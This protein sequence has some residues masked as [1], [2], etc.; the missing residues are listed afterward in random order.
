MGYLAC[1]QCGGYYR[2]LDDESP[3][4]FDENCECGGKLE[5]FESLGGAR[6]N[7]TYGNIP[8]T[9]KNLSE[10]YFIPLM[11]ILVSLECILTIFYTL[12]LIIVLGV[13]GL[14]FG[15][16]MLVIRVKGLENRLYPKSRQKIY[17]LS[18]IIFLF[19]CG[20]LVILWFQVDLYGLAQIGVLIFIFLALICGLSMIL[21]TFDQNNQFNKF[22]PP[23]N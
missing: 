8:N 14:L 1:N 13:I 19:Q 18:S 7:G 16:F 20:A 10:H 17:L 22:D 23:F 21:K 12:N 2:L 6:L 9:T 3:S 4:D 15:L 11:M 5:Y